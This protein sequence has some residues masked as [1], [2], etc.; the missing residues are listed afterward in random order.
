MIS[1]CFRRFIVTVS[2]TAEF[3]LLRCCSLLMFGINFGQYLFAEFLVKSLD[4]HI[5]YVD[6]RQL[7]KETETKK[8][9]LKCSNSVLLGSYPLRSVTKTSFQ[10]SYTTAV[11]FLAI[12]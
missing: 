9:C 8:K 3:D 11:E 4:P 5:T 1:L 6:L 2:I 12:S 7:G 10:C